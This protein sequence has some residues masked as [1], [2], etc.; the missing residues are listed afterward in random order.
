MHQFSHSR[1]LAIQFPRHFFPDRQQSRG[2]L[3]DLVS[4]AEDG[5]GNTQ[6]VGKMEARKTYTRWQNPQRHRDSPSVHVQKGQRF[7]VL[8]LSGF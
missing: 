8:V 6:S 2:H 7:V 5:N 3:R 1:R 4:G